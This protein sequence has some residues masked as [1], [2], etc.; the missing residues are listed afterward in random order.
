MDAASQAAQQ[1]GA[2]L[3]AFFYAMTSGFSCATAAK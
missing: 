2:G 3:G 1:K